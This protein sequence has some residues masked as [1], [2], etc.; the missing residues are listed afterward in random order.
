MSK[1]PEKNEWPLTE[2]E[3]HDWDGMQ[4]SEEAVTSVVRGLLESQAGLML[5]KRQMWEKLRDRLGLPKEAVLTI[6]HEKQ[7]ARRIK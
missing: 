5:K 6:D 3:A 2:L 7:V 1:E 4:A